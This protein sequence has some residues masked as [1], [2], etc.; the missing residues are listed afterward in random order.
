MNSLIVALTV[1]IFTIF[2]ASLSIPGDFQNEENND[3]INGEQ[4]L[5]DENRKEILLKFF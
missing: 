2:A 5:N 4:A 3:E 1:L